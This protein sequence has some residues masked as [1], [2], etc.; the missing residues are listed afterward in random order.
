MQSADNMHA[1]HETARSDVKAEPQT[2][3]VHHIAELG[4][5]RHDLGLYLHSCSL[6]AQVTYD[7]LTCVQEA[8]KNALRFATSPHGVRITVS[9]ESDEVLVMVRD[10]GPGLD[11]EQLAEVPPDPLAETGRGL[12]LLQTLMDEVEFRVNGGTEV[13][14]RKRLAR[15]R[16]LGDT[17]A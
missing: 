17:A 11:L 15:E 2:V 6:P 8:S 4:Q 1:S 14:L 13:R 3:E 9:L 10:H 5:V 16:T 7:L 12:F